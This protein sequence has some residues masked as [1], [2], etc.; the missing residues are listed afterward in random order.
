MPHAIKFDQNDLFALNK[1]HVRWAKLY[2]IT[3][4]NDLGG[5]ALVM[6]SYNKFVKSIHLANAMMKEGDKHKGDIRR[7]LAIGCGAVYYWFLSSEAQKEAQLFYANPKSKVAI[8]VWN[9]P[10]TG[11]VKKM[12]KLTF[13]SIEFHKKIYINPEYKRITMEEIE[14]E[15]KDDMINKRNVAFL[16][17]GYEEKKEIYK[18]EQNEFDIK[19]KFEKLCWKDESKIKIRVICG[20]H[21]VDPSDPLFFDSSI[22]KLKFV[23]QIVDNPIISWLINPDQKNL[24]RTN[25]LESL[26]IHIHGGGFI[27]MSSGSHQIYTRKWANSLKIPIFSIDYGLSPKYAYPKAFDD[28]FQAYMWILNNVETYFSINFL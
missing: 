24:I 12:M 28:C 13:P 16:I 18:E 2:K 26:I 21:L 14:N 8:E 20:F 4:F 3:K 22:H 11:L 19:M 6:N 10:D 17:N 9:L 27:S 23:Q 5:S 15:I 25:P 7:S 1:T